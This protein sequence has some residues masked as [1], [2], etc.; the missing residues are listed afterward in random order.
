ML[1]SICSGRSRGGGEQGQRAVGNCP[2]PPPPPPLLHILFTE[3]GT[4]NYVFSSD[5]QCTILS[6]LSPP[7]PNPVCMDPPLICIAYKSHNMHA[8]VDPDEEFLGFSIPQINHSS[9][10]SNNSTLQH[11]QQ[12]TPTPEGAGGF[13]EP[14]L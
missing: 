5:H 13:L 6:I 2:P 11:K 7:F 10:H 3:N 4:I 8:G 1:H 12:L 14:P 9:L